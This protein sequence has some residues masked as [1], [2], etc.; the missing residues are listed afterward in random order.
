[1]NVEVFAF[2]H[3]G[4]VRLTNQDAFRVGD[5]ICNDADQPYA[6]TFSGD[7][8]P[9][10]LAVTDGV[11]SRPAGALASYMALQNLTIQL[12]EETERQIRLAVDGSNRSLYRK[13]GEDSN[14]CGMGCTLAGIYLT[15]DGGFAF[16]VGDGYVGAF[17]GIRFRPLLECHTDDGSPGGV[18]TQAMGCQ[19]QEQSLNP[20]ISLLKLRSGYFLI[21]TDGVARYLSAEFVSPWAS[22]ALTSQELATEL[23][24]A[25]MGTDAKDNL[26]GIVIRILHD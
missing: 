15:S 26:T 16:G 13:M 14:C 5:R 23:L 24:R 22:A 1:M 19:P 2:T 11:A 3:L 7:D 12:G 10:L 25:V 20:S 9:L 17:N 4:K 6:E 8:L 18:L 21:A